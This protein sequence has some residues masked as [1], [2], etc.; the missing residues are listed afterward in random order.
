MT[1]PIARLDFEDTALDGDSSDR[2]RPDG[3]RVDPR[4]RRLGRHDGHARRSL[5]NISLHRPTRRTEEESE[6]D[7]FR[8]QERAR[9]ELPGARLARR[10]FDPGLWAKRGPTHDL[11]LLRDADTEQQLRDFA[12]VD[13]TQYVCFGDATG[14]GRARGTPRFFV[15]YGTSASMSKAVQKGCATSKNDAQT[16]LQ[17][18]SKPYDEVHGPDILKGRKRVMMASHHRTMTT[19]GW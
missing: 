18:T 14:G 11:T 9:A 16:D 5:W 12:T 13:G 7:V 15:G 1:R 10:D 4:H 8:P 3:A 17:N 2:P 19:T 6:I